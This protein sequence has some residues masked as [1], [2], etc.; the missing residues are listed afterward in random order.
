[1]MRSNLVPS[2]SSCIRPF[3]L[4]IETGVEV[5]LCADSLDSV[6][7]L[8][9]PISPGPSSFSSPGTIFSHKGDEGAVEDPQAVRTEKSTRES[10]VL[11]RVRIAG[12]S[13][14]TNR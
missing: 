5:P 7:C 14:S 13:A 9:R 11:N 2:A 6:E 10:L 12:G 4:P 1:M 8:D 3:P